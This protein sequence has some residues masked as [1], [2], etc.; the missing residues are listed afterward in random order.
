MQL[1]GINGF[2]RSGKGTTATILSENHSG[3]VYEVGFADKL[4][5]LAAKTLGFTERD[6]RKLIALMDEAKESW[7]IDII[8]HVKDEAGEFTPGPAS[9]I[10]HGWT[11]KEP[12]TNITG[13]QLLQN[14]GNEA[15]AVF[16]DSFWIDQVLP[17]PS[18]N[19][20][21]EQRAATNSINLGARFP[22][23]DCV[24][25]TD[26][27]YENEAERIK[28]LG[29]VVW[30]VLRP[31]TESDGHAS[32]KPLPRH[33]VDFTLHNDSDFDHLSDEVYAA[34]EATL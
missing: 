31:E 6:P 25:I 12:V 24:A 15:R 22:E 2:K 27:R 7:V 26:L 32:E 3:L 17:R 4:K 16:G 20:D 28:A 14:L 10:S 21:R 5:I 18:T 1:V 13:R 23:I 34:I 33:L 29:G 19:P 8:K 9:R 30:E 11:T